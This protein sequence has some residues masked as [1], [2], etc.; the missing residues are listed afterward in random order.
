MK[1]EL[2]SL[3]VSKS[4]SEE[5]TAYTATIVIDGVPAFHASNHGTGGPDSYHPIAP[6]TYADEKRIDEWLKV[7]RKPSESHGITLEYDLELEVGDLIAKDECSKALKRMLKAKIVVLGEDKGKPTVFTYKAAPT[8]Q[9]IAAIKAKGNIVVNDNP[10][11]FE[12]TVAALI[13]D[14]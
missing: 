4:L 11:V 9:N 12:A 5:T 7:N 13:G 6:F 14:E 8:P 10:A 2:K 1:I 3:K